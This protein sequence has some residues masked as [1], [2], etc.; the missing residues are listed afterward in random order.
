MRVDI[1]LIKE[2]RAFKKEA[3]ENKGYLERKL[4]TGNHSDEF[5][6]KARILMGVYDDQIDTSAS[7]IRDVIH[8]AESKI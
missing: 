4:A 5:K 2:L 1:K 8:S 6:E 3:K 7:M